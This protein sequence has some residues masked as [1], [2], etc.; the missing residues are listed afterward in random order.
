VIYRLGVKKRPL[1]TARKRVGGVR[2]TLRPRLGI[3][4]MPNE[5]I[6]K[7]YMS[8]TRS[9]CP[10]LALSRLKWFLAGRTQKLPPAPSTKG[11]FGYGV[12]DIRPASTSS[13]NPIGE[14]A[15]AGWLLRPEFLS[16]PVEQPASSFLCPSSGVSNRPSPCFTVYLPPSSLFFLSPSL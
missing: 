13:L 4:A 12:F 8:H 5:H 10:P 3:V 1:G 7:F 15:F 11:S 14:L 9:A 2:P 6:W 16:K